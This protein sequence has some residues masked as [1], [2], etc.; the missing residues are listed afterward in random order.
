MST[1]THNPPSPTRWWHREADKV[2]CTLCPR[3]CHIK[4]GG[5]GF[6]FVRANVGNELVLTTWGRSSGFCIDPIEKKPLNHFLP[7]T[8][9]MSLGTAGCNLGCK[10]CQNHDISKSREMDTLASVATP[11]AI[12]DACKRTGCRS[13]AFTYN[14][15]T[16]WA[17]YAID[18]ARVARAE[19]IRTVAVTAG[20]ISKEARGE[21]YSWMDAANVDLKGFTE[22]FYRKLTQTELA[23]VLDTLKFLKHE[24]DVWFELTNLMIPGEN[25][26]P[27]ETRAMCDWIVRELGP[28]VPLHF[29]AFHPDFKM[30]DYPPTPHETLIRARQI[31]LDAGIHYAYTGNVND[32]DRQS[33]Y[34]HHCGHMLIERDWYVLGKYNLR[35]NR[36]GKCD[37]VIPGVFDSDSTQGPVPGTWG[38][39]RVPVRITSDA[40]DL[41]Q[42]SRSAGA[43]A[44]LTDNRAQA[45]DDSQ[46]ASKGPTMTSTAWQMPVPANAAAKVD[47]TD[48]Q[49]Q[50]LLEHTRELVAAYARGHNTID[51]K[52]PDDIA[53]APAFGIFVSLHRGKALRACMGNWGDHRTGRNVTIGTLLPEVTR[54]AVTSDPRFPRITVAEL[55]VLTLEISLMHNPREVQATGTDRVAAVEVGTHGLVLATPQGRG[56]LLPHVAT[57]HGWDARE[58]LDHLAA[59]AG[60][61]SNAWQSEQSQLLTFET[62]LYIQPP[63]DSEF[64]ATQ[65]TQPVARELLTACESLR[66]TGIYNDELGNHPVLASK[67][68]EM[69][70]L[71]IQTVSG[72]GGTAL[73][74]NHSMLSLSEIAVQQIREAQQK[75]GTAAD[76]RIARAFV[77]WQPIALTRADYP[78]RH[79]L[80]AN[81][82][83]FA[84]AFDNGK[85]GVWGIS[86]PTGQRE[87]R[88][89][90]ALQSIGKTPAQWAAG[91]A[92]LTSYSVAIFADQTAKA[93]LKNVPTD[94]RPPARAGQFYPATNDAVLK[95]VD[96]YL[97]MKDDGVKPRDVRAVML[98][99]AGWV[100][101]GKTIGKTLAHV[102]VP[103]RVIIIGPKHTPHGRNVSIAPHTAWRV[104]STDATMSKGIA[105]DSAMV[106]S[107]LKHVDPSMQLTAEPDA[108]A[109]EHGSEVLLPF[110]HR[111]NP[112]VRVTPIAIGRMSFEHTTTFAAGLA[113]AV[114]A[115]DEPV[116]LVISSDMNHFASEAEGRRRDGLALDAMQSG[117]AQSLFDTCV[118][119]EISMCGMIPAAIIMQA[120][121]KTTP[122]IKPELIHYTTSAEASGKT[123]QVVGYA[124][125]VIA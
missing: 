63:P 82:A 36:C 116:L 61:P 39:R 90:R 29:T 51:R 107:L 59:K 80:L 19:G 100:Y 38:N 24:T 9:V 121:Q 104:P 18:I 54:T 8:P 53:N 7:G 43:N 16:I 15:P 33:T 11:E 44:T 84:R 117:D 28:D 27:D 55:P 71:F 113:A 68:D 6:C 5:R 57:E 66:S 75:R 50:T 25:D 30:L 99:H 56:L 32:G 13:V 119:N 112:N 10:F 22:T 12:V 76:D 79:Q 94:V 52:L 91:E 69:L 46:P 123:D 78:S 115:S 74:P 58:F 3:E 1:L 40:A 72:I 21:F 67:A 86:M 108:H 81:C 17:E 20:Y 70:G 88:V 96:Q 92:R 31:A 93:P 37:A 102:N 89:A 103:D 4:E 97:A 101:C 118:N 105:I 65:L 98:P 111:R 14:D 41:V 124:G 77:M 110:L 48:E 35:G 85:G 125:V 34:C 73:G 109:L 2:V 62:A 106:A 95:E 120:L 87:D 47:F 122:T 26:S 23:P 42:I 64:D 83:V 45:E 114:A 49:Q 60:L